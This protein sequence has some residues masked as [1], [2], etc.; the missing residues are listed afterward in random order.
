MKY[1]NVDFRTAGRGRRGGVM[2]FSLIAVIAIG[3]LSVAALQVSIATT[4]RQGASADQRQAFYLAEAGLSEAFTG[5]GIGKTGQV[6]T[7]AEPAGYGGGLFWVDAVDLGGNQVQ[8][9]STGMWGAGRVTLGLVARGTVES[10]AGLGIYSDDSLEMNPNVFVDSFDSTL[11]TYA[12][13]IDAPSNFQAVLGSNG[14]LKLASGGG[15]RGDV[16]AGPSGT[17]DAGSVPVSGAAYARSE[18]GVMAP[19]EVPDVGP[20]ESLTHDDPAPLVIPAG[21]HGYSLLHLG[22]STSTLLQGP[23]TLV[24]GDL[25][26]GPGATLEIDSTNGPVDVFVTGNVDLDSSATVVT[27][28]D[29]PTGVVFQVASSAGASVAFAAESTFYGFLYAPDAVVRL[30]ARFTVYGGI[31]AKSFELAT[32][33]SI[34]Y[35]VAIERRLRTLPGRIAWRVVDVPDG[36]AAKGGDPFEALG[37]DR[38]ALRS[39]AEA[40]ADQW[41]ASSYVDISGVSQSYAGWE[42][43]FD[44]S[45]V[46]AVVELVRDGKA[47]VAPA[48][49]ADG[50]SV[51]GGATPPTE[52]PLDPAESRLLDMI[53]SSETSAS[54]MGALVTMYPV[55]ESILLAAIQRSPPM[56]STDLYAVLVEYGPASP[57]FSGGKA[58]EAAADK[59]LMAAIDQPAFDT[60]NLGLILEQ[61]SP[62]NATVLQA[63]LD[64]VPALTVAELTAVLAVQ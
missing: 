23:A 58:A 42:S 62:L 21:E 44:W 3:A 40:H 36:L 6:G 38:A 24:V 20:L 16:V 31:V 63:A 17:I 26:L 14:D 8:L 35:D 25:T 54:V 15:V 27:S 50:K 59:V 57:M 19:I 30:G 7:E 64:R 56:G 39:P 51:A 13:Q 2:V 61:N 41:I 5:L 10:V 18:P 43:G 33:G 49:W 55:R 45:G 52:P 32:A 29:D 1:R 34:H 53:A 47:V 46:R 60:R 4:K 9:E 48:D 22:A 28:V 37:V 12:A 11:G